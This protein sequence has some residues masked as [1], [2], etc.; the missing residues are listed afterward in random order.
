M[1]K[2]IPKQSLTDVIPAKAGT[3]SLKCEPA[4]FVV[5]VDRF[6]KFS[7]IRQ[8]DS[9]LSYRDDRMNVSTNR[10]RAHSQSANGR[11]IYMVATIPESPP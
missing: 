6:A 10:R 3:H 5:I 1:V 8:N 9:I 4:P 11:N 2:V 7:Y